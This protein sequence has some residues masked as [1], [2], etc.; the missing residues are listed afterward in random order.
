MWLVLVDPLERRCDPAAVAGRRAQLPEALPQQ[1]QHGRAGKIAGRDPGANDAGN[2]QQGGIRS[3]QPGELAAEQPPGRGLA[4]IHPSRRRAA[5]RRHL[6]IGSTAKAGGMHLGLT[7]DAGQF[8][9]G[10]VIGHRVY[11]WANQLESGRRLSKPVAGPLW[12]LISIPPWRAVFFVKF[13][14]RTA[15]RKKMRARR[16]LSP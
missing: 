5:D 13:V 12:P 9:W 14:I 1:C 16:A 7:A 10:S 2:F 11:L 3:P 4:I 6:R 8:E 15:Q